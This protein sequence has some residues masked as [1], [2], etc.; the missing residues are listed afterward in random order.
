MV[1]PI[2]IVTIKH[3][4]TAGELTRL[5]PYCSGITSEVDLDM[6]MCPIAS[7]NKLQTSTVAMPQ[8]IFL[9]FHWNLQARVKLN[10]YKPKLSFPK[11][12]EQLLKKSEQENS[13]C[14]ACWQGPKCH[15]SWSE[16]A[17][18][19]QPRKRKTTCWQLRPL[20]LHG[21]QAQRRHRRVNVSVELQSF[22]HSGFPAA[23]VA[24]GGELFRD[25]GSSSLMCFLH[26]PQVVQVPNT[27]NHDDGRPLTM[28]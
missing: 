13:S 28:A 15:T 14:L 16:N 23:F 4:H 17:Q 7:T 27:F 2:P 22:W 3:R 12:H 1:S 11:T 26:P 8:F 24:K 20:P 6:L 5:F 18:E 25:E 10:N 21:F 9:V 19:V